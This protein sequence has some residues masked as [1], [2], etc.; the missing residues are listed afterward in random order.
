M[1]QV[2]VLQ[3]A[4]GQNRLHRLQSHFRT[5]APRQ[6]RSTVERHYRRRPTLQQRIV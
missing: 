5:I 4:A 2:I 1:G 3:L 6:R